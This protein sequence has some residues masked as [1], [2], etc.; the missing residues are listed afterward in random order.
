MMAGAIILKY[1]FDG[2]A[3]TEP[4]KFRTQKVFAL[5]TVT[6]MPATSLSNKHMD[7]VVFPF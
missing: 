3:I 5:L 4:V 7:L 1:F 6:P 2:T